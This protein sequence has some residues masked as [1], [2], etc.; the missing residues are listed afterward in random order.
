MNKV[1]TFL[2]ESG[3]ARFLLPLGV[4]L[5]VFGTVLFVMNSKNQNYVQVE[6]TVTKIELAEE[7]YTDADGN[8]VDATYDAT[9]KYT[10]EGKDYETTLNNVG[11]YKV[12]EKVKIYY[13]PKDPSQ[14]TMTKSVILPI[15][16]IIG[17]I[18]AFVAGIMS[19]TNAIKNHK[20]MKKQEKE[21]EKKNA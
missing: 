18:V 21:W 20:T 7:A 13:N 5:I 19:A 8:Q 9:V 4:I 10:V 1:A 3:P 11:K 6:S 17:G 2:R 16:I 15:A 14:V 12:G